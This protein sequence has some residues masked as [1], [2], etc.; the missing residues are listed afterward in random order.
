MDTPSSQLYDHDGH[1]PLARLLGRLNVKI[2]NVI[3][4][5]EACYSRALAALINSEGSANADNNNDALD[6]RGRSSDEDNQPAEWHWK[7]MRR[8]AERVRRLLRRLQCVVKITPEDLQSAG[9]SEDW[10][11]KPYTRIGRAGAATARPTAAT[12][13]AEATTAVAGEALPTRQHGGSHHRTSAGTE[14]E[15]P[16]RQVA[17]HSIR[18]Y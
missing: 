13:V 15:V 5:Y 11:R 8:R 17:P 6:S 18:Q 14:L 9:S 4:F 7:R 10:L 3:K 1:S 12:S 2:L 16:R